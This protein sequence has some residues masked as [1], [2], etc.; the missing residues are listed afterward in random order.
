MRKRIRK[1]L[2]ELAERSDLREFH[3]RTSQKPAKISI[4]GKNLIDFTNRD[5]LNLNHD[6]SFRRAF[7]KEVELSGIGAGS[8]RGCSGTLS[9]HVA[10]EKR[11]AEFLGQEASLIF[12]S[13]NQV[14]LSIISS[15]LLEGDC[16]IVDE[17]VQGSVGDAAYLMNVDA[18]HYDSADPDTLIKTIES[19]GMYNKRLIFCHAVNPATGD[20]VDVRSIAE[21]SFRYSIPLIVD[22]SYS[23]GILGLR[24]A[25]A[26]ERFNISDEVFCIY[27]SLGTGLGGYGA[28]AAGSTQLVTYI[29]NRSYTFLNET[30]FPPPL[31][32]AIAKGIDV[33]ELEPAKR[34]RIHE[35]NKIIRN[36]LQK[37]GLRVSDSFE[38]AMVGIPFS[39]R[40]IAEDVAEGLFQKGFLVEVVPSREILASSG[41]LRLILN[42]AHKMKQIDDFIAT[43][44]D[45][46]NRTV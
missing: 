42:S 35:Y 11:V 19:T 22:E 21:I 6:K 45:I 3:V 32:A 26:C 20:V 18:V 30:A 44:A 28:F 16:I 41:V 9:A 23:I 1:E 27:G 43:F 12:S 2:A 34:E 10:L 31:A 29:A 7:Q 25:G 37:L 40:G 36:A 38:S 15:L 13:L 24:G 39:D 33:I 46:Y 5:F 14:E 17:R 4:R 8:S